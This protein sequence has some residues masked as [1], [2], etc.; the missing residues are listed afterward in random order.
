MGGDSRKSPSPGE[1]GDSRTALSGEN[2][3]VTRGEVRTSETFV[4]GA[5]IVV[6]AGAP[7]QRQRLGVILFAKSE[8]VS[9]SKSKRVSRRKVLAGAAGVLGA[10]VVSGRVDAQEHSDPTKVQGR[11][12]SELGKRSRFEQPQRIAYRP[13]R[14]SSHT[15]L[16]ELDGIITPADLHFERHHGGVPEITTR[17]ISQ[18]ISTRVTDTAIASAPGCFPMEPRPPGPRA[19]L[20]A[21]WTCRA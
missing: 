6:P 12:A 5:G 19:V 18:P 17:M 20:G 10:S 3:A 15:P 2:V 21:T 7:G 13:A 4:P 11:T 1:G 9:M 16:Q 8:E 14:T